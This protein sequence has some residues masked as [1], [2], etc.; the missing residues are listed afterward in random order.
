MQRRLGQVRQLGADQPV[1]RRKA[2]P[3]G[4]PQLGGQLGR[5]SRHPGLP[6]VAFEAGTGED[7]GGD[8]GGIDQIAAFALQGQAGTLNLR[9]EQQPAG[10]GQGWAGR[11]L[12]G[13]TAL[14]AAVVVQVLLQPSQA[15]LGVDLALWRDRQALGDQLADAATGDADAPGELG[16]VSSMPIVYPFGGA[17]ANDSGG[18]CRP[19]MSR[20]GKDPR[21]PHLNAQPRPPAPSLGPA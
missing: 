17:T 5:R 15:G 16:L 4:R 11:G 2:G 10:F 7:G 12:P 19:H 18:P 3:L 6:S 21:E 8:T 13:D 14:A 20:R 9:Q 1:Q